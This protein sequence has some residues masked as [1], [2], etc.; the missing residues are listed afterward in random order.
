MLNTGK[1]TRKE[2]YFMWETPKQVR[3]V[4]Y[5]KQC[6]RERERERPY[7]GKGTLWARTSFIV[8]TKTVVNGNFYGK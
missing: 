4:I 5:C 3:R 2:F 7:L 6:E 8:W 1:K